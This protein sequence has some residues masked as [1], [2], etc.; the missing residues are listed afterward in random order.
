MC[1]LALLV[2]HELAPEDRT[3][4]IGA[5]VQALQHRG[6]D[7]SGVLHGPGFSV[8]HTRLAIVDL[9]GGAQ[10]LQDATR[11]WT[12]VFNG[13]IYN[14]VELRKALSG[15]WHF[16]DS[17]DTEVLLA[18]LVLDGPAFISRLDGMWAFALH[19]ASTGRVLLSRDRFG[20]KPLYYRS[21]RSGLACASELPALRALLPDAPWIEDPA[22]VSDYF[23]FGYTVPGATC[24]ADVREVL[25]AHFM[26]WSVDGTST[27]E[28][29]WSPSL[30]P[31][32]GTFAEAAE[33]VRERLSAAVRSRQLAADV[34]VGAFLSGGVDS[35]V[36]CAL[37]QSAQ[38]GQLRTFTAGFAEP[39]FDER[40]HA[41][42]AAVEL[43][44][45]H[46]AGELS[47]EMASEFASTLP[48]RIGQPFG[49][50]SL[51]PT[52][53]V[54]SLA[55]Q[56]VKVVLTGDGGDEVFGGYA[57]YAGRLLRQHYRRLPA[58]LRSVAE[59]LVLQ[60]SE[61]ISHHSGSFLKRAHLFVRL[62][63]EA[64]DGY[65]APPAIRK[66]TLAKLVPALPSGN[67]LPA[68]PWSAD[69]DEL[70]RMMLLDWLVWLP[71]DILAKVDRASMAYSLEA[72][73]PFLDRDLVEFV[74]RVPWQWHFSCYRGKQLLRAAMRGRVPDFV[75]SRRKQGFASPV[76]HW[77]RGRLG[78][79]LQELATG[80]T[81][82][83]DGAAVRS[84][85]AEHRAG[86]VDHSQPLWLVFAYLRWRT[87]APVA[88]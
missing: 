20:K 33:E 70:R 41:A 15:R 10:P 18:G 49:D 78:D 43:A 54:S 38:P 28:R 86:A 35:T 66:G 6:P 48:M 68:I 83:V 2:A 62:V 42:R 79:Q 51:V 8:G 17:S 19:D 39:T 24:L 30:E 76:A 32:R 75:W 46:T 65:V 21:F 71:Q 9:S 88:A 34:E 59:A 72:R 5:A 61:P 56:H 4:R 36:V 74:V 37:A 87:S 69:P 16:R 27:S 40:Q 7:A 45:V 25:P 11:R 80:D 3:L 22:G 63:R 23:K 1:G 60:T 50:A 55:A 44:T 81:G 82:V 73:C 13:E 29:Y 64:E 52:A 53:L 14:F 84:V 67:P 26:I 31:W 77:M 12:L 57:R 58:S 85:L 47:P